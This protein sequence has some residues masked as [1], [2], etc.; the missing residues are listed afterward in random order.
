MSETH[1]TAVLR[2]GQLAEFVGAGTKALILI[3][4]KLGPELVRKWANNGKA[5]EQVLMQ[6]LASEAKTKPAEEPT[7]LEPARPTIE[8]IPLSVNYDEEVENLVK[9]GKY[10]RSGDNI[11]SKNF[12]A[13]QTGTVEKEVILVWFDRHMESDKVVN[14]LDEL[15]LRPADAHETLTFGM[16]FPEGLG[17]FPFPIVGLGSAVG[18]GVCRRVVRFDGWSGE[19][20]VDLAGWVGGWDMCYR[21]LAFRK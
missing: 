6:A 1:E 9:A 3:A 17:A 4:N 15:G 2:E 10:S 21:F 12:P 18:L 8:I 11:T 19:R 16:Q 7:K 14:K 13:T 20:R 5:M